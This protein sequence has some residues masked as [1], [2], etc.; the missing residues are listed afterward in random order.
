MGIF[1]GDGFIIC[2]GTEIC[3]YPAIMQTNANRKCCLES[4]ESKL[5]IGTCHQVPP[6][7]SGERDSGSRSL[8]S[9][10]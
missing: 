7:V 1:T 4:R 10:H 3:K 8:V 5:I 6:T 9:V 2:Q